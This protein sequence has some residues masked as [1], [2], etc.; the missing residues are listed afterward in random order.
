MRT[1]PSQPLLASRGKHTA[2]AVQ[3]D[4]LVTHAIYLMDENGQPLLAH[5]QLWP[6]TKPITQR[7]VADILSDWKQP[8]GTK[9][10]NVGAAQIR[11]LPLGVLATAAQRQWEKQ[12]EPEQAEVL[13]FQM[14]EYIEALVAS[15]ERLGFR[16][17]RDTRSHLQQAVA[18]V[19][20]TTEVRDNNPNPTAAV[21][22]TFGV[23]GSR[24]TQLLAL[25]RKNGYLTAPAR[26]GQAGGVVT[27]E[28]VTL[29]SKA[30]HPGTMFHVTKGR[31]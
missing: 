29:L 3:A 8:S 20:Y 22:E 15:G 26:Q 24:A 1:Q 2:V 17:S 6:Q 12:Q 19:I 14:P 27:Q 7:Q 5:L 4:G 13:Q 11:E 30:T 31:K 9:P 16:S 21:A 18:A 28:A 23:D 10:A 25:A